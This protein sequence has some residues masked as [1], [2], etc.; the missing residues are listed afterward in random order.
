MA[1]TSQGMRT[2]GEQAGIIPACSLSGVWFSYRGV[3]VLRGA[4]LSVMPGEL[5]VLT[6][7][8]GAGKSTI[9]R[10]LLGELRARSGA[11]EVLGE[12]P[13]GHVAW[14]RVGYVPQAVSTTFASF[15]ATVRETLEASVARR[16]ANGRLGRRQARERSEELMEGMELAGLAARRLDE[17][18]GGQLQRVMLARA[19]A[20]EPRLVVLDEP[21]SGLDA[22][23][24]QAFCEL[25]GAVAG[26]TN[27]GILLVTHDLARLVG[28]KASRRLR[29]AEGRVEEVS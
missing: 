20:N 19:L 13:A 18:S 8:N 4:S 16:G 15:P 1:S 22:E 5:C 28:I 2:S 9:V 3:D 21:T 26:K 7:D 10:L 24:A 14:T 12:Q 27:A 11:V 17:L 6:G 25:A 23:G 29:L